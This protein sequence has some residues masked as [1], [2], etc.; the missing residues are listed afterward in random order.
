M[1][2]EDISFPGESYFCKT[3]TTDRTCD[4]L[5]YSS[6]SS[7]VK[8]CHECGAQLIPGGRFCTSCGTKV[9]HTSFSYGKNITSNDAIN[10]YSVENCAHKNL[11]PTKNRE[12]QWT[13]KDCLSSVGSIDSLQQQ[14]PEGSGK[15]MLKIVLTCVGLMSGII[16]IAGL[17]GG[18]KSTSIS[19]EAT[20]SKPSSKDLLLLPINGEG[21]DRARVFLSNLKNQ[22]DF[23]TPVITCVAKY[24]D[25]IS[26]T[27][28]Y[29]GG[30]A[31]S[32]QRVADCSKSL[33]SDLVCRPTIDENGIGGS[34]ACGD[35]SKSDLWDISKVY[36]I[37]A[38]Q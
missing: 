4:L 18:G 20:N 27:W 29:P 37:L 15:I 14:H 25:E 36:S 30:L 32:Y 35:P 31:N 38:T 17:A 9:D 6:Y 34:I 16:L 3:R 2:G 23:F 7:L 11:F 12:G 10:E 22:D 24:Y 28:G 1:Y 26:T 19:T 8:Y 5:S 21:A 13:C 33:K